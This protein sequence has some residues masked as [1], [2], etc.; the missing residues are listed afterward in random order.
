VAL[1]ICSQHHKVTCSYLTSPEL[2][3]IADRDFSTA[4]LGAGG[5]G[6]VFAVK[7]DDTPNASE[8]AMKIVI[9]QQPQ[10]VD[11]EF[12]AMREAA[13]LPACRD[14]VIAPVENSFHQ[15]HF[16]ND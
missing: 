8:M 13:S 5:Y 4:V 16:D 9:R 2:N 1:Q 7:K 3:Q 15:F 12:N 10:T 11:A 6:R 14:Y